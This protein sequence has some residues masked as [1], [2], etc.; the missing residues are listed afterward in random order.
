MCRRIYDRGRPRHRARDELAGLRE[1]PGARLQRGFE[2]RADVI[3]VELGRIQHV[4]LRGPHQ[5]VQLL[6]LRRGV[7]GLRRSFDDRR[8]HVRP[9]QAHMPAE[10]LLRRL[11]LRSR[12]EAVRAAAAWLLK[13][14]D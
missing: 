11:L 1:R 8:L 5:L 10:R 2:L 3:V 14:G 13:R 7:L 4:E 6:E 12:P 9:D